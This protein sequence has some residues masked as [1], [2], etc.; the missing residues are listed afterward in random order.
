MGKIYCKISNKH[1]DYLEASLFS[2]V[3]FSHVTY[4]SL[5]RKH[6]A[7]L[8]Y[9]TAFMNMF[10]WYMYFSPRGHACIKRMA[11]QSLFHVLDL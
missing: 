3:K 7:S 10:N 8:D 6:Q 5:T 4:M 1:T 9:T 11:E 2:I